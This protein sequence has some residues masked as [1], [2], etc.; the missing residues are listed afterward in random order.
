MSDTLW[1]GRSIRVLNVVDDFTRESL[2]SETDSSLPGLRV[3]SVL[4]RLI[5]GRGKPEAIVC[6]NG[7]EFT[8]SAMDQW[9][10]E[11]GVRLAFIEPGKPVQSAFAESFNGRMRDEC[12]NENWWTGLEDARAGI[13]AFRRDYN[14]NRPHGSLGW[15]TPEKFAAGLPPLRAASHTEGS[16]MFN[17]PVISV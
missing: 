7:P 8:G 17:P 6:D 2:A 13:E 14:R 3:A 11:T 10:F 15:M 12:L 1:D 16:T 4:D 5:A 9:A